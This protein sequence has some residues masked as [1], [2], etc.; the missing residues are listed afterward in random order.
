MELSHQNWLPHLLAR[1][2]G[3]KL[4]GPRDGM[5]DGIETLTESRSPPRPPSITTLI[6]PAD[7]GRPK[8]MIRFPLWASY[9]VPTTWSVFDRLYEASGPFHLLMKEPVKR[10]SFYKTEKLEHGLKAVSCYVRSPGGDSLE[11]V[12]A[13]T[14][15]EAL[16]ELRQGIREKYGSA[17]F[18]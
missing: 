15:R 11:Q 9:F 8:G 16:Q 13:P 12:V 4:K 17:K 5:R 7:E 14:K 2:K 18:I 6:G 1:Y 3:P 10:V